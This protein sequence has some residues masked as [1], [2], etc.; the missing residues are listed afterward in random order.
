LE[1]YKYYLR[2]TPEESSSHLFPD[3]SL[4]PRIETVLWDVFA[5]YFEVIRRER[6]IALLYDKSS[7]DV[8][9]T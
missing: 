4:K 8:V 6:N 1:I 9:F 7:K 2:K 5:L 3:G